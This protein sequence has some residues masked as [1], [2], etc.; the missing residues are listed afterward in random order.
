SWDRAAEFRKG[1]CGQD[2][3][4]AQVYKADVRYQAPSDKNARK[5]SSISE[6]HGW[7]LV[8]VAPEITASA[9]ATLPVRI[10]MCSCSRA[11][12]ERRMNEIPSLCVSGRLR[13]KPKSARL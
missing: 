9:Y 10:R 7:Q 8:N 12:L 4:G 13:E 5:R 2:G 11:A 1:C 3:G 6:T